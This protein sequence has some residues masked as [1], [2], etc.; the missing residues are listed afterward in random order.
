MGTT[1]RRG[2]PHPFY[3]NAHPAVVKTSCHPDGIRSYRHAI[4]AQHRFSGH[5]SRG[6]VQRTEPTPEDGR[7]VGPGV[8]AHRLEFNRHDYGRLRLMIQVINSF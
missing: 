6:R 2:R 5:I 3:R 4:A 1:G 7:M 8:P